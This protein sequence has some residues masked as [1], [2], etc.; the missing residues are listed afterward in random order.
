[1]DRDINSAELARLHAETEKNE[2]E[3]RKLT[4]EGDEIETRLKAKWFEGAHSAQGIV[5]GIVAAALLSAWL[6]GYFQPLLKKGQELASLELKRL[7]VEIK[8]KEQALTQQQAETT[9]V[10]E[11]LA[12]ENER[13][14]SELQVLVKQNEALQGGQRETIQLAERLK[15]DLQT[16]S[17]RARE[18]SS[19]YAESDA[20]R[21]ELAEVARQSQLRAEAVTRELVTL[22]SATSATAARSERLDTQLRV[23]DISGKDVRILHTVK[24][25][26]AAVK[27]QAALRALGA[28]V[29][30]S[31]VGSSSPAFSGKLF[32]YGDEQVEAA[33]QIAEQI[34]ELVEVKPTAGTRGLGPQMNLWVPD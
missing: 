14:R 28:N 21:G 24:R 3:R 19:K 25:S 13:V 6:V 16:A 4:L 15:L 18:F 23:R 29:S 32:Y 34:R 17:Q 1:M 20:R 11:L 12:K 33:K 26:E 31:E 2:A 9:R 10:T 22:R 7:E 27:I 8:L 30:L 5:A